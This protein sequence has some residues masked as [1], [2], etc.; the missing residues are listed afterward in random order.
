MGKKQKARERT[1]EGRV[2]KKYIFKR[3]RSI[4]KDLISGSESDP[5]DGT[6]GYQKTSYGKRGRKNETF[7]DH[8]DHYFGSDAFAGFIRL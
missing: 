2:Q 3:I 5:Y 4:S 8:G 1:A 6:Y 7:R